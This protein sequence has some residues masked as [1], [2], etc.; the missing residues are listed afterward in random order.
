MNFRES[1]DDE[2]RDFSDDL[3]WRAINNY[4]I[5]SIL[6]STVLL[7]VV[8]ASR[9]PAS[10]PRSNIN[11]KRD[12]L[13]LCMAGQRRVFPFPGLLHMLIL[14]PDRVFLHVIPTLIVFT[15]H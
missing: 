13:A 3:Q 15:C 11:R 14:V 6:N 8:V 1:H 7:R 4:A 10:P 2:V 9:G 12:V 5:R